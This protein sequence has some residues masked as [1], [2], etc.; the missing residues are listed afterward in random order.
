MMA[1]AAPR[2]RLCLALP[3]QISP[4]LEDAFVRALAAADIASVLLCRDD[5]PPDPQMLRRLLARAQAQDVAFLIEENATLAAEIGADGV[6]LQA[7]AEAYAEARRVLGNAAI[8]GV[9]STESRHEAMQL[10][11]LGADYLAFGPLSLEGTSGAKELRD[12]MVA[13]WSEIFVVP[14]LA[15]GASSAAEAS[16]LA[17]LGADFVALSP[18][19]WSGDDPPGKVREAALA[20]KQAGRST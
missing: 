12:Q 17:A 1:N 16:R 14:C 6:H 3:A 2:C 7:D 10:A 5:T 18:A 13:W 19:L 15:L 4:S 20:I 11:E 8:V 9:E